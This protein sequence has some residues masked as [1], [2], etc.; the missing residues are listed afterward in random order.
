MQ[1]DVGNS[2]AKWR[3]LVAGE[4]VER[5]RYQAD[6]AASRSALLDCAP[7]PQAIWISSVADEKSNQALAAMLRERWGIEPW[8]AVSEAETLGLHNSYAQPERMGVDRWLAMLGARA[9]HAGRLC[10]VDAGSALT[11]DLVGADGVHE[12]GYIIPGPGLMERALLLD[13]DRVRFSEAADYRL[14]PGRSTAEAVRHGIA[15]AQAAAV[16]QA[17]EVAGE[18]VSL[19]LTGGGGS[20]LHEQLG[21]HGELVPDLVL[22]GLQLMAEIRAN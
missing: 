12:G 2:S 3:L 9:S 18:G 21:G 1:F 17:L 15:L 4:V 20:W 19:F 6:D 13:T 7:A 14:Q 22:D 10:V 11:I 16:R 5:G 8:F